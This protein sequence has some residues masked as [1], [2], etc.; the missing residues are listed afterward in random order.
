MDTA[1]L[2][3]SWRNVVAAGD[4]VPLYFYSHLFLSHPELRAMFPLQM[5]GQRD[6]LVTALGAV[7]SNVDELDKV[8]PLLEQLGRDHRRFSVVTQ[9]YEAVGASLLATLKRFLGPSW[10]AD[11][12]DTWAQAYGLV[13][14][15]MV[16]AAEQDEDVSPA[17]WEAD[18][19]RVERR[20]VEVAVIEVA[21]REPFPYRAGQ[22]VAVE[23]PQRPRLWRY[24]SPANAP[25]P[26]GRLQFHIQPIAG[27]LVSSAVVRRLGQGDT[28]KMGA[29]VGEQLTLPEDRRLP[30]LLLVAGGTGLAPLRAVLD[31]IDRGWE[32]TGSAPRVRLFHGSRMPWNL[33]D[34]EHLTALARKPWFDYTPVVSDDPTYQ[35]AKGLVGTVAAK[36]GDWSGRTAMVCGSPDMVRYTVQELTAAGVPA[37][38]IR[39]EQFDFQGAAS[40]TEE[41]HDAMETR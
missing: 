11:L 24:F 41:L 39:R 36:A 10:T 40:P 22:S 29:P 31:Q 13:A 7:I 16:A 6:K 2:K 25:D 26:T 3:A 30:D 34:H 12:A 9:H 38:S 28:I 33:Y 18:V 20:S 37:A 1:S 17:V 35:G 23:I 15:V 4:D 19:V 27:G 32:A 14:K 8:V 21:P 5:T